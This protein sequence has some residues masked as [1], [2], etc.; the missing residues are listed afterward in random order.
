MVYMKPLSICGP[1]DASVRG[2]PFCVAFVPVLWEA[3]KLQGAGH[4]G[5]ET[6]AQGCNMFLTPSIVHVVAAG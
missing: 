6:T 5:W 3:P 1:A 4:T 2:D